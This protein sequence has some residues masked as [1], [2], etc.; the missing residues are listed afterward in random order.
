MARPVSPPRSLVDDPGGA[1]RFTDRRLRRL[2]DAEHVSLAVLEP[3]RLHI[4]AIGN[5]VDRL[6][7]RV[8]VFLKD[9]PFDLS[10]LTVATMSSTRN[11]IC[12]GRP[13]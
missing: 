8:V 3:G 13:V 9:D 10:C 1:H 4:S 2:H 5:A 6:E 11:P 7:R 12:V